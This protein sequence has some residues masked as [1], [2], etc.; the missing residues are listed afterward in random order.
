MMEEDRLKGERTGKPGF[1]AALRQ[2]QFVVMDAVR[3]TQGELLA[4]FGFGPVESAYRVIASGP[5]WRLRDYGCVDQSHS[6][7][8]VAAPIKRPYIWDLT[9]SVSAIRYCLQAGLRVQLL[10]W[11]PASEKTCNVGIAECVQGIAA[12]LETVGSRANSRKSILMG[13]SLGGTLAGIYAA[14]APNTIAGLVL[15]SAP[16]CFGAGET[17]FRDALVSLLPAPVSAAAPY[18]GSL[19][20]QASAAASP[21]TFIWSRLMDG[22]FSVTDAHALDTFARIERWALDEVALPGKLVREIVEVLYRRDGFRRGI[23]KVGQGTVGPDHLSAPTL[24]IVNRADVVS[25]VHSVMALAEALGPKKFRIIE[26]PGE[27]GV[28][29]QH[30][31]ILVGRQARAQVWPQIIEWI[32]TQYER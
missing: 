25:P 11:L 14:S 9:R 20:S 2:L 1:E 8:I 27:R 19:L 6:V 5:H 15:L 31:G 17:P 30:L 24:A 26:Y 18:P 4:S 12:A 3:R 32:E 21:E 7:L 28:C 13:H 23:L 29:L 16:L 22:V 10:E